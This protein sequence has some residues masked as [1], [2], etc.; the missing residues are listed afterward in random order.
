MGGIESGEDALAFLAA[1]ASAIA[2]GTANFRDPAAGETVR[3]ELA[4]ALQRRG[5]SELPGRSIASTSG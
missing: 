3:S 5:L 4:A 1:G 2:V